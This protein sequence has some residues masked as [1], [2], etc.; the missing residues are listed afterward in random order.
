MCGRFY[1]NKE[2]FQIASSMV[3]DNECEMIDEQKD[4]VPGEKIPVIL[5][6][7]DKLVL[8]S[9][10]WGYSMQGSSQK[11]INARSETL[12]EK[13]MFKEDALNHRCLVIA[14]G[15]YEWDSH[16]HKV[17]FESQKE[18]SLLMGGIY[19]EKEKEVTI[20]TVNANDTMKPIHSRMPLMISKEDMHRWLFDEHYL[21]VFLTTP[22]DDL[23]IVSGQV[24][25]SLFDDEE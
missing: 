1:L 18:D 25:E 9:L 24:Q 8:T 2:T 6:Q 3:E 21:E 19:R 20:I 23:Q 4:Y 16:K 5:S 11:V 17:S 13:K 10:T 14:K 12:L 7:D 15:F 22:L